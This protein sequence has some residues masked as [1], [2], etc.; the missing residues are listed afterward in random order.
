M[1][2][3]N[4]AFFLYVVISLIVIGILLYIILNPKGVFHSN[5]E[6]QVNNI[7]QI[8]SQIAMPIAE[9]ETKENKIQSYKVLDDNISEIKYNHKNVDITF[10][11][12]TDGTK[13][14]VRMDNEWDP[15]FITMDVTCDDGTIIPVMSYRGKTNYGTMKSEWEDHDYF[16]AMTTT[17][18]TVNEIFLQEVNRM[19]KENHKKIV[20]NT[21]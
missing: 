20:E 3:K 17:N 5:K 16:Y 9:I 10:R 7:D 14:I 12:T 18:A 2:I 1:K 8:E 15:H 4:K 11:S 19:V 13:D 6:E 21:P